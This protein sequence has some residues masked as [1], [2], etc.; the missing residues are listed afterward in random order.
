M[1]K[2]RHRRN[3]FRAKST[4]EVAEEALP[5]LDK[6]VISWIVVRRDSEIESV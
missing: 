1:A 3:L 2:H 4:L 5:Y 6:V